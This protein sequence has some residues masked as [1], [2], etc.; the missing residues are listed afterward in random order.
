MKR[1][2]SIALPA[3]ILIALALAYGFIQAAATAPQTEQA[4][5]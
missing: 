1:R 4:T 3:L 5:Q 2:R